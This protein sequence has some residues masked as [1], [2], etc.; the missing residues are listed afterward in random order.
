MGIGESLM[1]NSHTYEYWVSLKIH[2]SD[3]LLFWNYSRKFC[4]TWVFPYYANKHLVLMNHLKSCTIL[5]KWNLSANVWLYIASGVYDFDL[6]K[7]C[8]HLSNDWFE[9]ML[10]FR[11]FKFNIHTRIFF[12]NWAWKSY[13]NINVSILQIDLYIVRPDPTHDWPQVLSRGIPKMRFF[14]YSVEP[15]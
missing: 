6:M 15:P 3:V 7:F 12:S 1:P 11:K 8:F 5:F 13:I 2:G 10:F 9:K 4:T 14:G